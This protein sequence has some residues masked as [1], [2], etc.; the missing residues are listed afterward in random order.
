MLMKIKG[1]YSHL[2]S[3]QEFCQHQ[4]HHH[5][6]FP[7]W[8]W[9]VWQQSRESFRGKTNHKG[10]KKAVF[11]N[12]TKVANLAIHQKVKLKLM[13]ECAFWHVLDAKTGATKQVCL[14]G[15][16]SISE[17]RSL[18]RAPEHGRHFRASACNRQLSHLH[19]STET[20]CAS[21]GKHEESLSSR[22]A[23]RTHQYYG[24]CTTS[25]CLKAEETLS[26]MLLWDADKQIWKSRIFFFLLPVGF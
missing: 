5:L 2:Q 17:I 19:L 12:C 15:K 22:S 14:W 1:T 26:Q 10:R 13:P 16:H 3:V 18:K 8:A 9:W 24:C 23:K 6:T 4:W 25:S 11:S 20:G 21:A 7:F